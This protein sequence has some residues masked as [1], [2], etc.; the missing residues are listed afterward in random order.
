MRGGGG[1][2]EKGEGEQA[3]LRGGGW[4][5]G[6]RGRRVG[7]IEGRERN[8]FIEKILLICFVPL[9]YFSTPGAKLPSISSM[10]LT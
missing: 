10:L 8:Q 6:R 3:G 1:L 4:I 9:S 7:W 2:R 5:E